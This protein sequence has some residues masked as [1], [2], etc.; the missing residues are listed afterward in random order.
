[1]RS[2]LPTITKD[3]PDATAEA[4]KRKENKQPPKRT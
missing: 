4:R 1:M 2:D 3:N